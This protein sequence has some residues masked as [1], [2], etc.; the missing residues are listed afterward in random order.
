MLR[1]DWYLTNVGH[2]NPD[3]PEYVEQQPLIGHLVV[4]CHYLMPMQLDVM[5]FHHHR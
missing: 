4:I 3:V 2:H 5:F 1:D